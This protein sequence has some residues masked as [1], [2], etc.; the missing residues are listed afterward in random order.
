MKRGR[1]LDISD[2]CIHVT[3]RCHNR[4][5]LETLAERV[6]VLEERP[7]FTGDIDADT[8]AAAIARE[9]F[10]QASTST[11]ACVGCQPAS[12]SATSPRGSTAASASSAT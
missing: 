1:L 2:C 6:T 3:Q 4:Q 7:V 9:A 10:P 12:A 5:W 8:A 11:S